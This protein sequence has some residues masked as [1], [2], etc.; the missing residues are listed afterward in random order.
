[1]PVLNLF[2]LHLK[3]E[4]TENLGSEQTREHTPK[5]PLITKIRE[6]P[7]TENIRKTSGILRYF[8]RSGNPFIIM[9]IYRDYE[10]FLQ[11]EP[12]LGW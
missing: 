7:Q 8:L 2:T 1:M 11:M 3:R 12:T 9:Y 4:E 6:S 5:C 10:Q